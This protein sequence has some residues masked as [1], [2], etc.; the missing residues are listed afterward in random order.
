MNLTNARSSLALT[1]SACVLSASFAQCCLAQ[2]AHLVFDDPHYANIPGNPQPTHYDLTYLGNEVSASIATQ[3]LSGGPPTEIGVTMSHEPGNTDFADLNIFTYPNPLTVGTLTATFTGNPPP[4]FA[5]VFKSSDQT[6]FTADLTIS[7]LV[8]TGAFP[9]WTLQA[10]D[11]SFVQ[12]IGGLD[13]YTVTGTLDYSSVPEPSA[14]ILAAL[15][16]AGLLAVGGRSPLRY[17]RLERF[18]PG[19]W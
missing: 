7:N 13:P 3:S 12:N 11:F 15:A 17:I 1:I 6:N 8:Y 16:A 5:F 19:W 10:F 4:T 9:H 18:V 14:Y 2:R